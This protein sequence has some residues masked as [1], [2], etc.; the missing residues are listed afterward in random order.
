MSGDIK[1]RRSCLFEDH[2]GNFVIT[3]DG[4]SFFRIIFEKYLYFPTVVVVYYSSF[5]S[6]LLEGVAAAVVE[7]EI[8][9]FGHCACEACR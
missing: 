1:E 4:D 2:L 7:F 9:T 3:C 8:H 6:E 5:D